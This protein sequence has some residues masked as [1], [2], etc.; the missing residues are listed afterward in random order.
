M[1]QQAV[2]EPRV[3]RLPVWAYLLVVAGYVLIAQGVGA[4]LTRGLDIA[5]ASPTNANELWRD[6]TVPIA[7]GL[8]YLALIVSVLRWWRPV[9]V[10][11]VPAARWITIIPVLMI[12]VS[13]V[14]TDY[15]ALADRGLGFTLLLLA[16]TL[17]VGFAEEGL[18]RGLGVAVFRGAGGEGG[19]A[20]WTSVIFGLAHA[21]N[22]LSSG[23]KALV[24]V[25]ATAAAGYFFYLVRRR[26]GGLLL[27][28]V[29]HALWD[30]SLISSAVVPGREYFGPVLNVLALIAVAVLVFTRRGRTGPEA[31]P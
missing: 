12:G 22:L 28:A 20:L 19:V 11:D 14:S 9:W 10:D 4:L 26:S 24:Q 5:Y 16:S 15:G 17:L 29:V 30:F 6:M 21:S 3:R 18:F 7:A 13:V 31:L 27:P 8:C 1:G 2:R 23:A 25:L